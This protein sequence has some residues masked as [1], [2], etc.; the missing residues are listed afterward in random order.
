VPPFP[1]DNLAAQQAK[2][3]L[4]A[5]EHNYQTVPI[6][7]DAGDYESMVF[8]G[9]SPSICP[10]IKEMQMFEVLNKTH[11]NQTFERYKHQLYPVLQQR[12]HLNSSEPLDLEGAKFVVEELLANRF[13]KRYMNHTLNETE[14]Y[15]VD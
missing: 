5:L 11:V 4:N 9:H 10:V 15:L 2:L 8:R 13:E 7:S 1:I 6:H 14:W 12:F 3:G